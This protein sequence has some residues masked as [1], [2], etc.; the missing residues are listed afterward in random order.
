MGQNAVGSFNVPWWEQGLV[1]LDHSFFKHQYLLCRGQF[2]S[3]SPQTVKERWSQ[4]LRTCDQRGTKAET[5]SWD[6]VLRTCWYPSVFFILPGCYWL[7]VFL[8]FAIKPSFKNEKRKKLFHLQI[9]PEKVP[10]SKEQRE[11]LLL[12]G[13]CWSPWSH[14]QQGS[15]CLTW[16]RIHPGSRLLW[17]IPPK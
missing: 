3:H 14:G 6:K 5:G 2:W 17:L 7:A 16:H 12:T 1:L 9:F 8:G 4:P 10:M 15:S 11:G 13:S